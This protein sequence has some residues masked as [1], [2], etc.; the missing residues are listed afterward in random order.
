[1]APLRSTSKTP[2]SEAGAGG[3]TGILV[4]GIV[5]PSVGIGTDAV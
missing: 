1:M 3:G 2:E 4:G 5:T